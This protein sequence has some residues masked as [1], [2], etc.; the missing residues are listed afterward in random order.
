MSVYGWQK[1]Y[2]GKTCV[3][4]SCGCHGDVI[5]AGAFVGL[6]LAGD[7]DLEVVVRALEGSDTDKAL[8]LNKPRSRFSG[9]FRA[10][11]FL[12]FG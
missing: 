2:M 5:P 12:L 8:S 4:K 7:D 11:F 10:P 9:L 1:E 3:F 6:M